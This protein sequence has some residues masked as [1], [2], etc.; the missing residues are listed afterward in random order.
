MLLKSFL[1]CSSFYLLLINLL[2]AEK[3]INCKNWYKFSKYDT[4]K[5]IIQCYFF[6]FINI[7]KATCHKTLKKCFM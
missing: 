5:Q 1:H 7:E 6:T 3:I 4:A 2:K